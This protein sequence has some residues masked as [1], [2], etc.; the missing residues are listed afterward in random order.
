[1]KVSSKISLL[2]AGLATLS[3]PLSA[4]CISL[5]GDW[6]ARIDSAQPKTVKLPGTLDMA[7]VGTP[8]TLKPAMEKPQLLR[9]TRK[10]NY[11]GP[12]TYS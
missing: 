5:A 8:S 9:L 12:C 2:I 10:V 4:Q 11:I 1:M 3:I 7:G 6:E